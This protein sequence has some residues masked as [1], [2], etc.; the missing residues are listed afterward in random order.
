MT[1]SVIDLFVNWFEDTESKTGKAIPGILKPG[2]QDGKEVNLAPYF[3]GAL[4][5]SNE[6][7]KAV[8]KNFLDGGAA[9]P[10]L[11]HPLDFSVFLHLLTV[12]Q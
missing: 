11:Y 4:K 8:C 10:C 3:S 2:M 1:P 12:A 7:G 9:E 5:S 6:G